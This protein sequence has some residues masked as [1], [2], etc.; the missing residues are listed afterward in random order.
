MADTTITSA[1]AVLKLTQASLF[2]IPVTIQNFASDKA[3]AMESADIA[4][5]KMSVDGQLNAGYTPNPRKQ[6]ISLMAGSSSNAFFQAV[7]ANSKNLR[8][9]FYLYGILILPATGE[10][11]E[12]IKGVLTS[13]KEAPDGAKTLQEMDFVITWQAVNRSTF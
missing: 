4:E 7:I 2:P 10:Q 6:T 13:A 3:F 8:E 9:I 5:I 1:N 11:F 12:L